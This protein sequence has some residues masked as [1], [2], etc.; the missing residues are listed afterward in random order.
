MAEEQ[1]V[2][3][4]GSLPLDIRIRE[5]TDNGKPCVVSDPDGR[6]AQTYREIARRVV[7]KLSLNSKDYSAKFPSIKI[8]S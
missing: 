1:K 6:I 2:D 8:V 7:A 3:F 4:L 5:N